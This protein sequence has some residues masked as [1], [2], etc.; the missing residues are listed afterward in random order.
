MANAERSEIAETIDFQ[1]IRDE[2]LNHLEEIVANYQSEISLDRADFIEYLSQNI[3]Y[4]VDDSMQNGLS[5]YYELAHKHK[6]I[7]NQKPLRFL[8]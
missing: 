5:L 8:D 3:S 6:L 1:K 4:T 7:E 2:G